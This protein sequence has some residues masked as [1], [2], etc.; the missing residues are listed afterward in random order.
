[1]DCRY[2]SRLLSGR[3]LDDLPQEQREGVLAHIWQCAACRRQWGLDATTTGPG[4]SGTAASQ[5]PS[6][7]CDTQDDPPPSLAEEP[8]PPDDLGGFEVLDLLGRGGVGVV[9]RARQTS[10][11]RIVALKVL[12]RR[13]A[14]D[15]ASVARFTREA[16]AAAA[17]GH[18]NIIQVYDVGQDR[19]WHYIAMEYADGGSLSDAILR[20]G[21]LSAADA[22]AM[23][24]QMAAALAETHRVGILHRDIKPSNI[25]LTSKGWAKLADFGPAKRPAVDLTVTGPVPTLGT[26]VYMAPEVL[27]GEQSDRR[28]D[29]YSLGATFYHALAG[30]PPFS[31]SSYPQ[32][33]AQKLGSDAPALE[34]VAPAA[35]AD[36]CRIIRRLMARD[37]AERP[38]EAEELVR[39]IEQLSVPSG[40]SRAET[41]PAGG[42]V[43]RRSR[44]PARR[45]RLALWTAALVML[46]GAGGWLAHLGWPSGSHPTT[47][48]NWQ[49][50]FDGRTLNGWHVVQGGCCTDHGDVTARDGSIVLAAG[51]QSTSM[52]WAGEF[53]RTNYE[54]GLEAMRIDGNSTFCHVAF[55]VGASYCFLVVGADGD[56]VALD[57]VDGQGYSE[58]QT[59]SRLAFER[60]RWYRVRLRVTDTEVTVWVDEGR[61][62]Q[63]RPADHVLTLPPAWSRLRPFG[64]GTWQT[65]GAIRGIALRRF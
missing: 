58:N 45:L 22:R 54:V 59:R 40:A 63:V 49:S 61:A 6:A 52:V 1:V 34:E 31:G 65:T 20:R 8:R 43:P 64:L 62:I 41:A 37:P 12:S 53:P 14:W 19:G 55:P 15:A 42:A 56:T 9:Y 2:V 60:R 51:T 18:P 33:V 25:L 7:Q 23:M 16:R 10:V 28:S 13:A 4:A 26:P 38:A 48:S 36:L 57:R 24:K 29:L 27:Q 11:E 5:T 21:P 47:P 3:R 50:M 32:L 46:L 39:D 17:A 44:A 30:R 35:G